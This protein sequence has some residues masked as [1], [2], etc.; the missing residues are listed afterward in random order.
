MRMWTAMALMAA[1]PMCV[2]AADGSPE[3]TVSGA[4]SAKVVP[5]ALEVSVFLKEKGEN[6]A[7]A[8]T[9]LKT[10]RDHAVEKLMALGASADQIFDDP[11]SVVNT[12]Q[13]EMRRR[14]MARS[15]GRLKR[16][17]EEDKPVVEV[18]QLV[19]VLLPLKSKE[20]A[21]LLIE[22]EELK[23]KATA[24]QVV[25]EAKADGE[26]DEDDGSNGYHKRPQ[27]GLAGFRYFAPENEEAATQA[28]ADALNRARGAAARAAK[29][30][31]KSGVELRSISMGNSRH[32]M[33]YDDYGEP[34]HNPAPSRGLTSTTPE[35]S[36][37]ASLSATFIVK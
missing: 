34:M 1:F 18:Q 15:G 36:V 12:T 11:A 37:S 24:A 23:A 5:V 35:I 13:E 3:I 8:L 21:A 32:Q 31:G 7:A 19:R 22:G 28:I 25:R 26:G 30:M 14:M 6:A 2:R 17:K 29:A 20:P 10:A 16:T 4:G 33:A 9:V 27:S